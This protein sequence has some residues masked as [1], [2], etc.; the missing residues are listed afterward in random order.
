MGK[1]NHLFLVYGCLPG[2]RGVNSHRVLF[3]PENENDWGALSKQMY[4]PLGQCIFYTAV[5]R[6]YS[7]PVPQKAGLLRWPGLQHGKFDL[8]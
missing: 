7:C 2:T 4:L 8:P 3:L 1:A 5:K 6:T